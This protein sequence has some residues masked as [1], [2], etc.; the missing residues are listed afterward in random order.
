MLGRW[1]VKENKLFYDPT[2][3]DIRGTLLHE[4][5]HRLGWRVFRNGKY[6]G[7]DL[8]SIGECPLVRWFH[9]VRATEAFK[10]FEEILLT[11]NNRIYSNYDRRFASHLNGARE[12]FAAVSLIRRDVL[13]RCRDVA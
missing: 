1:W 9:T 7:S 5:G 4:T 3:S 6:Y 13:R 12:L 2:Q 11:E 8:A 10:A